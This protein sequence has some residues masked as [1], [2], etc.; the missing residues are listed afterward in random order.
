[1]NRAFMHKKAHT[2][3]KD[4]IT[5]A[6]DIA[7][8]TDATLKNHLSKLEKSKKLF[9]FHRRNEGNKHVLYSIIPDKNIPRFYVNKEMIENFVHNIALVEIGHIATIKKV[10]AK[11]A[12]I[13]FKIE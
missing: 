9:H 5:S 12:W 3:F 2:F 11:L 1:M 13:Q 8:D 4:L 6:M 10:T 7:D